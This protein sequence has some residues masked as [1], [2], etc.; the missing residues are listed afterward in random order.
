MVQALQA[1]G[2]VVAMTGDG[3]ND[4]PALKAADCSI[5][6]GAGAQAAR[7]VASMILLNNQFDDLPQI[8]IQGRRVINNIQ[9]TASLFLV[10]TLFSFGL[11][12]LT[13]L[14]SRSIPLS[15]CSFR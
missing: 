1:A 12:V 14:F 15:R 6:M 7:A 2:H 13:L 11:T 5:A 9:R 8:V 4:V 10:K 3:V